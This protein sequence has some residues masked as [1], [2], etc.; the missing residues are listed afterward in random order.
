M[1]VQALAGALPQPP[2]RYG[3]NW[4]KR[5]QLLIKNKHQYPELLEAFLVLDSR[6]YSISLS[7]EDSVAWNAGQV[8]SWPENTA[9]LHEKLLFQYQMDLKIDYKSKRN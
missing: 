1:F 7:T 6:I 4:L 9:V 8:L 3:M 2:H 5:L